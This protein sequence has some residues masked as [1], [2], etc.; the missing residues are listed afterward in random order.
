MPT[1]PVTSAPRQFWFQ[2]SWPDLLAGGLLLVGV[3]L[4]TVLYL[5][6]R[7][8]W[9][10]EYQLV[11]NILRRS[12]GGLLQP[13]D[14]DQG[15]PVGFL[16]VEKLAAW[17]FGDH[18]YAFRLVPF[19][20][21]LA[22]LVLFFVIARSY[23]RP[24]AFPVAVGL[25]ALNYPLIYY[26]AETKQYATD[27]AITLLLHLFALRFM[28][29]GGR[30][31][32]LTVSFAV[33]SGLSVWFSHPAIFTLAGLGVVLGSIFLLQKDGKRVLALLGV[34]LTFS[35]SFLGCYVFSLRNLRGN[36]YLMDFWKEGFPPL[37]PASVSDL[38]WFPR[39]LL[40]VLNHPV[41]FPIVSLGVVAVV[42][43]ALTLY[44]DRKPLNLHLVPMVFT[45]LAAA[46]HAYPFAERLI[47][48]LVPSVLLVLAAGLDRMRHD[49]AR[50][51]RLRGEPLVPLVGAFFF[52]LFPLVY[53]L[54]GAALVPICLRTG[55]F[56]W[57]IALFL[58]LLV[59]WGAQQRRRIGRL[60]LPNKVTIGC[61]LLAGVLEGASF[62]GHLSDY[63]MPD[64]S[65]IAAVVEEQRTPGE[66]VVLTEWD[67]M[68]LHF[69]LE[70]SHEP[71][72]DSPLITIDDFRSQIARTGAPPACLVVCSECPERIASLS[73]GRA[74]L[75]APGHQFRVLRYEAAITR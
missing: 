6:N 24:T 49:L 62:F 48:F 27:V 72:P 25:F 43:G 52:L 64:W 37:P 33:V 32:A 20:A 69:Y 2:P 50:T 5:S 65:D 13:L 46:L 54:R 60:P 14:Y 1:E 73:I 8:L 23:L 53:L 3:V 75:E 51:S 18:A 7:S 67:A 34:C 15:A 39:T 40:A 22:S 35:L 11:R 61:L 31:R 71:E 19:L 45:L 9:N 58:G 70:P 12:P 28:G 57:T 55:S 29:E 16:L 42:A 41:G 63:V 17:L 56:F 36:D 44:Q 47:L 30:S 38:L 59:L 74:L 26:A 66:P 10:D 21:G 68:T 4:R